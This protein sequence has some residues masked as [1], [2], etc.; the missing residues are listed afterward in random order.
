MNKRL[1]AGFVGALIAFAWSAVVHMMPSVGM[2]GLSMLN[3][4]E[5]TVLGAVKGAG[6]APGLYFFPGHDMSKG[7]TKAEDEAWM[8][9]F[10]AGPSGLL[11]IEPTPAE[12]MEAKQLLIEFLSTFGCALIA[13]TV[14][15]TTV[16]SLTSRALTV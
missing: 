4:K 13:A 6:L 5:D 3:E 2:M 9:K 10:R 7:T 8:A 15:A 14:L 1:L 11:L 12:P 16:G